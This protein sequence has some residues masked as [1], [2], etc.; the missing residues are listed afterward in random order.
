MSVTLPSSV[1]TRLR[2]HRARCEKIA[3][4]IGNGAGGVAGFRAAVSIVQITGADDP[5]LGEFYDL[6]SRVFT[7]EDER[8]PLEGFKQV[9]AFNAEAALQSDYGP[10]IEP[11]LVA[12]HPL[13]GELI[14]AANFALYAYPVWKYG[15]DYHAS[16]QLHFLLVDEPYRGLG[17]A[18]LLLDA[19]EQALVSFARSKCDVAAPRTFM[20]CEQNNPA[21][22]SEA[23]IIDDALA[24]LIDPLDRMRWWR[25]RG[26]RKLDFAY[27]Q[28]PLGVTHEPCLYLDYYARIGDDENARAL[29]SDVLLE[30]LRRFFFVSVGKFAFNMDEN[31]QWL[32]VKDDLSK[33]KTIALI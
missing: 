28:P 15:F 10:F 25:A 20:T 9:L 18:R 3:G 13:S 32:A 5:L 4:D 1:M 23:Q 12:R 17:I 22:M 2:E 8:E 33:R 29:P 7:L 30:H 6:Y 21:R 14:G 31:A 16:C 26:F 19:V 27:A 11:I 24:A